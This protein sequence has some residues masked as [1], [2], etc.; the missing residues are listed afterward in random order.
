MYFKKDLDSSIILAGDIGKPDDRR[1]LYVLDWCSRRYKHVY[2]IA[3]NHEYYNVNENVVDKLRNMCKQF[4][5][6]YFLDK[7]V[8]CGNDYIIFG[9]TLWTCIN[10]L[11]LEYI[12]KYY[13]DYKYIKDFDNVCNWH[14]TDLNWLTDTLDY[15]K[16]DLRKKIIITHHMPSHSLIDSKYKTSP[17]NSAFATTDCDELLNQV[18]YWIYGHTHTSRKSRIGDC[19]C[20]CNPIGYQDENEYITSYTFSV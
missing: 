9:C 20:I 15:Y 2:I 19:M 1:F 16:D 12:K 4:I 5:N 18:D 8:Y 3:G 13:N 10:P 17:I 11:E 6:I 7:N 14:K